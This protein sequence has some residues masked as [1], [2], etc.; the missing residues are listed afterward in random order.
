MRR[1][2]ALTAVVLLFTGCRTTRQVPHPNER[3]VPGR[4]VLVKHPVARDENLEDEREGNFAEM[5]RENFILPRAWPA[6]EIDP[7]RR[8][9]AYDDLR[10]IRAS[11]GLRHITTEWRA[12]GPA[13]PGG[14]PGGGGPGAPGGMDAGGCAWTSAGP[15][16]INGRVTNI[17][18][19]PTDR[20]RI[21][22][23]T[24][25]GIW[26]SLDR[27]RR[28]QRVSDE[29]LA[30]E[31]AS[32]AINPDNP[33]EVFVGGGDPNYHG[34][35]GATGIGIWRS[36]TGGNPGTWSKVSPAELDNRVIY[37][38][39]IDPDGTN[40]VYAATSAGV[41]VGTHSG[42]TMSWARLGGFDSWTNDIAVDFSGTPRKVYAGVRTNGA[43]FERGIWKWDGTSWNRRDTGVPM[44]SSRTINLALAQSHPNTL[45]A[46]VEADTGHLQGLYKTTTG[47]TSWS[48]LPAASVLDDSGWGTFWY[49]WYNSVIEVDPSNRD[50]VY[51][52]GLSL[53]RTTNGGTSWDNVSGGADAAWPQSIHADQHAVAFDPVNPKIVYSGNDGGIDTTS[54]TSLAT[55]R[56]LDISHGM[57]VTEFYRMTTQL[58]AATLIAGGSQD[59]GTEMSFGNRTWYNP[60]GCDGADVAV[61]SANSDTLYANCNGGLY[62]LANPVPGTPGGGTAIT[63][64][65]P[66]G[67][68]PAPPVITNPTAPAGGA[69]ATAGG[70]CNPVQ[71]MKTTD[72]VNW[73]SIATLPAGAR[74]NFITAAPG[75]SFQHYY[76]GMIY[77]P[78]SL[79]ACPGFV[80]TPFTPVVWRTTT[81]GGPWSTASSGV[82][83]G[84][85]M[86]AVVDPANPSR[87][88]LIAGNAGVALT[89]D[90]GANWIPV[91][92]TLP[93]G[94]YLVDGAIDPTDPNT[95]YLATSVGVFKG[96]LTTG[97]GTASAVWTPFDEGL[98][99]GLNITDMSVNPATQVLTVSSMGHAAY[100]R[101]V[102]PGITCPARMLVVRDN[103]FDRG[104]EPSPS[105][106]P[107]SEHPIPD[108]L[109]P[110][111]Y[112]PDDTPG[113]RLYWWTSSDIR[114]DVPDADPP[115]NQLAEVDHVELETCPVEL[116]DC[117]VDTLLDSQPRRGRAARG[118]V[119]VANRGLNAITN[120]RVIALYTDATTG[121]PL[122]PANFWSTTFPASGPCGALDTSTGWNVVDSA[123]PCKTIPLVNPN[124]PEVVRFDWNVP[125][126]AAEHSCFLTIVEAVDDP[127]DPA[128]R[129][130]NE[131]RLWVLVPENRQIGLRNLHVVDPPPVP[132]PGPWEWAEVVLI[133]NPGPDP[134]VDLA[135]SAV[136]LGDDVRVILPTVAGVLTQDMGR[137]RIDPTRKE[138]ELARANK[139]DPAATFTVSGGT[140]TMRVSIPPGETWRI[141][142]SARTDQAARLSVV[143]SQGGTVL[144]GSTYILRGQR[145]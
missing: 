138:L 55:W 119:Q 19:D 32:I 42:A 126:S 66:P 95:L 46:K 21:F 105:S 3:L 7:A 106:V 134:F 15:T 144:G 107:D 65:S 98:P 108:P 35:S 104:V 26:R 112:K 48:A 23:T 94:S 50:I 36:T 22:V 34:A 79:T 61:D 83:N 142:L 88:F 121:L 10:A 8:L 64:V 30:A 97:G 131:R 128:V 93:S 25:G 110:G 140:G 109:R 52:G 116:P 141:V 47:G 76:I 84:W 117:P 135:F 100:H 89:T 80:G 124:M 63:W 14:G 113:G 127:L 70:G 1:S 33:A 31:L 57:L 13:G 45:Y 130:T 41:Y 101:D 68:G 60:G 11:R 132:L 125:V 16:N 85:L 39:R 78:P 58:A 102:R 90:G 6:Q 114:I 27:G 74:V 72:G 87:A 137:A 71:I 92:G 20:N 5:R 139:L 120:V 81:G 56:W 24:V 59:N 18:V 12:F 73:S 103:V 86:N 145:K 37:R 54:D 9:R 53:F 133:P 51:A 91:T 118:Y 28:W 82:P 77:F 2:L 29:F 67:L 49:S 4:A 75:T 129:S 17:A 62:E 136:G 111:F 43:T 38:L 115:K 123:M 44:T 40:D 99:D 96:A 69:L 143:A 122:L